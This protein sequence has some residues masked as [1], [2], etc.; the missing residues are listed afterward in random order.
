MAG[1]EEKILRESILL[2]CSSVLGGTKEPKASLLRM[3]AG[4]SLAASVERES[5]A[6]IA[7]KH[8]LLEGIVYLV[9]KSCLIMPV[10]I[11]ERRRDL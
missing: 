3:R 8:R 9:P 6:R 7:A 5:T 2:A 11:P 1:N 10:H 4:A